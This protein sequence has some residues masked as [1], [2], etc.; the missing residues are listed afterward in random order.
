MKKIINLISFLL[1]SFILVSCGGGGG[2]DNDHVYVPWPEDE[3]LPETRIVFNGIL[4]G[5]LG[6]AQNTCNLQG[7]S[8]FINI[9]LEV[10]DNNGHITINTGDLRYTGVID[11]Y[12]TGFYVN[13]SGDRGDGV[14]Y[15][16]SFLYQDVTNGVGKLVHSV[17][18]ADPA[19]GVQCNYKY[20]GNIPFTPY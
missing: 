17:T 4:Q 14:L 9:A 10:T 3:P 7:L 12:G 2:H 15:H 19:S 6:I 8:Q 13:T 20:T 5:R 1:F 11:G 16:Y 18:Y